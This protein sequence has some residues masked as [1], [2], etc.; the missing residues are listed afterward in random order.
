MKLVLLGLVS[1]LCGGLVLMPLLVQ[2]DPQAR[3]LTWLGAAM[4]AR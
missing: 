4:M 1:V 3:A 2:P